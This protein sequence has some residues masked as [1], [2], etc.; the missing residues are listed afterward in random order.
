[1]DFWNSAEAEENISDDELCFLLVGR[2]TNKVKCL[3]VI[4][5]HSIISAV[6]LCLVGINKDLITT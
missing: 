2:V 1:M 5:K 3:I 6:K 4:T